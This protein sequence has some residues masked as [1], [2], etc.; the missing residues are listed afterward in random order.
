MSN[1][2]AVPTVTAALVTL[3]QARLDAGHV[4][5]RVLVAPGP[6]DDDGV[7]PRVGVHLYRISRNA[8]LFTEDL[9]TRASSGEMRSTPRVALD[10]HYLFTF[11]GYNAYQ[12]EQMLALCAAAL[13]A[14][15]ELGPE[16][17]EAAVAAHPDIHETDLAQARERVR[18]TPESL[19]LDDVNRLWALYPP[20]SFTVTL[21]LTAGPVIVEAPEVP[22]TVLPV[23]RVGLGVRTL[24]APRLDAAAGPD[25]PGAPIRSATPMPELRLFGAGLAPQPG[26]TLRVLVD[27]GEVPATVVDAGQLTVPLAG[28]RP[29][30]HSVRVLRLIPPPDPTLS[31]TSP[32]ATSNA[33]PFTVLPT[34]TAVSATPAAGPDDYTGTLAVQV[35]PAV[36]AP[37]RVRVLLDRVGPDATVAL[38]VAVPLP[39]P[40]PQTALTTE[41]T[42]TPRGRYRVTLEIDGT[43]SI[44]PVDAHGRFQP[45]E[46]TL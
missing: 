29:G 34:L 45:Q 40:T 13:H 44:P 7:T 31:S 6:L 15:P 21:A 39:S 30:T 28:V 18:L 25:G 37:Q 14:V 38:A 10:L 43:R 33:V 2:L 26:E 5:P 9:P 8:A 17:I 3:I 23:R 16:L 12:S 35:L 32:A 22:G 41:L 27:G 1:A 36:A 19:S 11:R 42:H 24:S 20:G 4:N 46:V